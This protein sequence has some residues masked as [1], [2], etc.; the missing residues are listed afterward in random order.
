M[1][2]TNGL[3]KLREAHLIINII[4]VIGMYHLSR[5]GQFYLPTD[6]K[7]THFLPLL[8]RPPLSKPPSRGQLPLF[9]TGCPSC[10]PGPS[11]QQPTRFLKLSVRL[12]LLCPASNCPE[13]QTL[14]PALPSGPWLHPLCLFQPLAPRRV[15]WDPQPPL[16]GNAAAGPP[17]NFSALLCTYES[18]KGSSSSRPIIIGSCTPV[19]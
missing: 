12:S 15:S 11:T 6:L 2:S 5:C 13:N 8:S 14:T 4:Q 9:P 3:Q 19:T 1:N 10:C 17:C 7:S 16:P 18:G